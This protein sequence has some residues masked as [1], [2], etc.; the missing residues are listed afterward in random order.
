M[1]KLGFSSILLGLFLF[2]LFPCLKKAGKCQRG[3]TSGA[4]DL[5]G[6][7]LIGEKPSGE[8]TGEEKTLR[9]KMGGEITGGKNPYHR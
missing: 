3:T 8:K 2:G 4:K 1:A 9:G 6:K 7:I 5:A